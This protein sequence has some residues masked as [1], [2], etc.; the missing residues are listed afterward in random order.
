MKGTAVELA[1]ARTHLFR[2]GSKKVWP[3][4]DSDD[5]DVKDNKKE[6][7][8]EDREPEDNDRP[9]LKRRTGGDGD[10]GFLP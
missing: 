6:T 9:T 7:K 5:P 3:D 4:T 1:A 10:Q 8:P 2:A